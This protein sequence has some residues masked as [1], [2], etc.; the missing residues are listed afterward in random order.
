MDDPY[1]VDPLTGDVAYVVAARQHRPNLPAAGCPFCPGGREA[2]EPYEA[3]AF[4]NRW[5][6]LPAGRAE[7]VL[8]TPDHDATFWSLGPSGARRVV[9]LWADRTAALGARPDVAYVLVFENRGPEVG[10][11]ITHP[12]GQIY[13][14]GTV[15][16]RAR[17][18]L[19]AGDPSAL[20]PGAAGPA[21]ERLVRAEGGWR[22]WVP[23]A[24][25]WP[26]GLVL[27][28]DEQ[29]PDLPSLDGAGRDGL[30]AVLV[31]VLARYDGLFDAPMPYM[32]WIHQ[33]PSDGGD[34]PTAWLH[35]HLA[36]LLRSA[37][38]PRFVAAGEL[39]SDVYFNPVDP[40]VAAAE[41]R[42]VDLGH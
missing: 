18:E 22:A 12:H 42:A 31:D 41:L 36:P 39:G 38:T 4:P 17:R 37:G 16:P 13:A 10:A 19:E 6:P 34:W 35:V 1:R 28:P 9:D 7:V 24:P 3:F 15:P 32:L 11:T 5:P 29:V 30:A 23:W 14:F 27:A 20:A 40:D 2:P 21:G 8:Y 33:R 26:Y 25:V